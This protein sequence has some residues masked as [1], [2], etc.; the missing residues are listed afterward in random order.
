[1]D[2]VINKSNNLQS[3]STFHPE[4]YSAQ[5]EA[6]AH[7]TSPSLDVFCVSTATV[8]SHHEAELCHQVVRWGSNN[9]QSNNVW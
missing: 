3:Y 8:L 7:H 1:M 6:G 2:I 9:A 4:I 5:F